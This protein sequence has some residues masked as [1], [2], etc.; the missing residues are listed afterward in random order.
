MVL[1]FRPRVRPGSNGN[2][3]M[4]CIPQSPSITG[5][6]SSDSLVSY[7]GY[8]LGGVLPPKEVQSVYSTPHQPIGQELNSY[9]CETLRPH[10]PHYLCLLTIPL[11]TPAGDQLVVRGGNAHFFTYTRIRSRETGENKTDEQTRTN[12]GLPRAGEGIATLY[13]CA[14][15]R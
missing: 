6:S 7:P 3:V 2:E 12:L 13:A 14:D 8:S 1:P 10:P 15:Y 4:I 9:L 5:T 11:L